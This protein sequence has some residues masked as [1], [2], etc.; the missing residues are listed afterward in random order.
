MDALTTA[1]LD[2]LKADIFA[3]TD[4]TIVTARAPATRDDRVIQAFYNTA[5]SPVQMAWRVAVPKFDLFD[6]LNLTQYDS[7]V[8]GKRDAFRMLLD[9]APIDF[10]IAA[11]RKAIGD[12]FSGQQLTD[13]ATACTEAALR[14][15]LLWGSTTPSAVGGVTAIKRNRPGALTLDEVSAAMNRP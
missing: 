13:M 6:A 1:Q 9:F 8:A 11:R 2:Q 15:E 7:I 4:P 3:Q 12:I 5:A 14:G 10:G